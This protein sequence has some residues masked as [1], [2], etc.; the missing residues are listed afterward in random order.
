[1]TD[2]DKAKEALKLLATC[3]PTRAV[4]GAILKNERIIKE[5]GR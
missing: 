2:V 5:K 4:C 1:M 3:Y